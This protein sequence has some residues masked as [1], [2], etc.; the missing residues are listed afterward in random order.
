ML[1][2][3][4][5]RPDRPV[6]AERTI[7]RMAMNP[8]SVEGAWLRIAAPALL[9]VLAATARVEAQVYRWVDD[10]GVT[11]LSSE[12]PPRGVQ[13]ERLDIPGTARRASA[14]VAR[15]ASTGSG[16]P[17]APAAG[18]AQVAERED[19]LSRLRTRECVIALEALERKTSGAEA[20]SAAEIKRFEQTAALNCSTD[21]VRRRQQEE[22]AMQLRVAH[23]PACD[24][25]RDRLW[26]MLEPGSGTPRE[27][28]RRQ[29][30][31]VDG[32]CTPP[33]R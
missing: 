21:P 14:P 6:A 1:E 2:D 13:A 7:P 33:V 28:V 23:G 5:P 26:S 9:L 20:A 32:N 10:E 27:Q 11:H 31:F 19:L 15:T 29:Q 22:M 16:P 18:P 12:K 30:A 17:P 25:A 3:Y 24:E 8:R 4:D